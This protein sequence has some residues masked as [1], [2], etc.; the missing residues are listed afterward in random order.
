MGEVLCC[1][2]LTLHAGSWHSSP[3]FSNDTY[4]AGLSLDVSE[5]TRILAGDYRNSYRGNTIYAGLSYLPFGEKLKAGGF[6]VYA[7]GYKQ[8]LGFDALAGGMLEYRV[9]ER[10]R[11]TLVGIPPVLD[12][13]G[14][15]VS[16]MLE[17]KLKE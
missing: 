4:G 9:S 12:H 8:Y 1:L 14:G 5:T 7:S 10:V 6:A 16:L 13:L 3:Q 15:V 2:W 17:F 11:V